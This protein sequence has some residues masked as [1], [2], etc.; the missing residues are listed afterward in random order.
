MDLVRA[1][2][3]GIVLASLQLVGPSYT[4]PSERGLILWMCKRVRGALQAGFTFCKIPQ[5]NV[6]HLAILTLESAN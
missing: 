4:S 3:T 1:I 5:I 6:K 2:T